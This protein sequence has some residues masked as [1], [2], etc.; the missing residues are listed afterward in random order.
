M[1]ELFSAWHSAESHSR[2]LILNRVDSMLISRIIK[3]LMYSPVLNGSNTGAAVQGNLLCLLGIDIYL[4]A[5]LVW[6]SPQ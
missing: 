5:C 4:T 2:L 1:S 6:V 3:R